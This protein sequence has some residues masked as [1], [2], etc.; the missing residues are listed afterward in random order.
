[1]AHTITTDGTVCHIAIDNTDSSDI[2][3]SSMFT[4]TSRELLGIISVQFNPGASDDVLTLKNG[5]A[6][7]P[8]LLKVKSASTYDQRKTD[9]HNTKVRPYLDYSACTFSTADAEIIIIAERRSRI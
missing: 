3:F 6:S 1:M 8:I 2:A 7:G 5:S 9:F 4:E